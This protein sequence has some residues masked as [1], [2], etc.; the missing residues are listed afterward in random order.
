MSE[1]MKSRGRPIRKELRPVIRAVD[2]E[3]EKLPEREEFSLYT[4]AKAT[5]KPKRFV[6]LALNR[7]VR[8]ER[9]KHVGWINKKGKRGRPARTFVKV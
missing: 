3:M 9:I 4:L 1:K 7:L 2:R 5:K 8:H 6:G